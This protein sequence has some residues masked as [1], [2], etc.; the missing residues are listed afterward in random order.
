[1][2]IPTMWAVTAAVTM[3]GALFTAAPAAQAQGRYTITRIGTCVPQ[4]LNETGTVVG[5]CGPNTALGETAFAW[6]NGVLTSLGKL[7]GAHYSTAHA[8]NGRGVAVGEG[9]TGDFR[10]HPTM[11]RNRRVIDIDSSVAN[12]RAIFVNEAG[13]VLGNR[14]KG[15]S[16]TSGWRPAIW[17]ERPDKPGRFDPI[18]LAP[19]PGGDAAARHAYATGANQGL[20]VVGYVQNSLF[21]QRGAFWDND[22]LHTLSLLEPLPGDWQS[23]AWGVNDLGQAVG[24]SYRGFRG[25]LAVLW[26]DNSSRTVVDL[27]TLPG[28]TQSVATAINSRGQVIGVSTAA[29]G[30]SRPFLWDDGSMVAVESLLDAGTDWVIQSVTAINDAGEMVGTGRYRGRFRTFLMTPV[31]K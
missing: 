30:S 4:G 19:Y 13:V 21:G 9:D 26:L 7:R 14:L 17:T 31:G 25:S 12:G 11:Y 5:G 8:V 28:D 16:G 18:V 29:D 22:P 24:E 3:A 20:Q 15:F 10:P 27:G 2:T 1:M 6:Q 23:Y